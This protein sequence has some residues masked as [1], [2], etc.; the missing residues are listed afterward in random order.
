MDKAF[1]GAQGSGSNIG[2]RSSAH[3]YR[4]ANRKLSATK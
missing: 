1:F 3:S 4:G 2:I